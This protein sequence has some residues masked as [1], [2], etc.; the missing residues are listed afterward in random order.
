MDVIHLVVSLTADPLTLVN[1]I[2]LVAHSNLA[3][4]DVMIE[5]PILLHPVV[6]K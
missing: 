2:I 1:M 3:V 5:T 4:E 6:D